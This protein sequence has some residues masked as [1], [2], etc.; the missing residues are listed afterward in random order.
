MPKFNLQQLFLKYS[1]YLVLVVLFIYFSF[2]SD[3][4]LS[5]GN[6]GNFFKQIPPVGILTIAYCMILITGYV[7]LSIASI[8]ALCGCL[9]VYLASLGFPVIFV[10]LI[11]IALGSCIAMVN[12]L[13]IR[14]LDLP[15]FILTL[16]TNYII[17]GLLMFVTNGIYIT[18]TQQNPVPDYFRKIATTKV[19]GN[20]IFS[21][22][23]VFIALIFVFI[24]LM[25]NTRFG[26]YC[27]A[28][29]SNNEAARLSGIKTD[30]HIIK[31][32]AIEG[33]LAAI[34]GILLMS[35][36]NVGGPNEGQGLD[37]LA[38]AAAIMGGTSFSGGIG[39]IG[40]AIAGILTLQVF[41]N[42]LAIMGVNAFMQ[43]VVTG[44]VIVFAIIVDYFRRKAEK[45]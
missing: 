37:L 23:L 7:D 30:A 12:A 43:Q 44:A 18:G 10:F 38:M 6:I 35:N 15:S 28:I 42:G 39:T 26:K 1:V 34:A 40:G 4:F 11:P 17:R 8:A 32:F 16:G 5:T 25:K 13:L 33:M 41:T 29:G 3:M 2:A 27:Y 20:I 31:V 22:T 19:F 45:A 9:S 21:N 36:L 14:K 24:Y